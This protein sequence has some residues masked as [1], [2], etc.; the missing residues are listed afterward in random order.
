MQ[1]NNAPGT[2]SNPLLKR[3]ILAAMGLAVSTSVAAPVDA[4]KSSNSAELHAVQYKGMEH[5]AVRVLT[6]A[7]ATSIGEVSSLV[8]PHSLLMRNKVILRVQGMANARALINALPEGLGEVVLEGSLAGRTDAWELTTQ[9]VRSAIKVAEILSAQD[10]V[11]AAF[12]DT[13]RLPNTEAMARAAQKHIAQSRA[14]MQARINNGLVAP[15]IEPVDQTVEPAGTSDPSLANFWHMTNTLPQYLNKD[16]NITQN[17]YDV[18]GYTGN[19]VTVGISRPSNLEH[20]DFA[21]TDIDA[22]YDAMLTM[23]IDTTLFPPDRGM[24]AVAGIIA[25]ERDNGEGGHGIAPEAQFATM[26]TGTDLLLANMLT[27]EINNLDLK[28]IPSPGANE[29]VSPSFAAGYNDGRG[30]DFVGDFFRNALRFGRSGKGSIFVFS[31]GFS[32]GLMPPFPDPYDSDRSASGGLDLSQHGGIDEL[33]VSKTLSIID[34]E[35]G[36]SFDSTL[37]LLGPRYINAQTY[38]YPFANDRLTFLINAVG[39]DGNADMNQAIGPGV[40]ASVYTGTSNPLTSFD[41]TFN[42]GAPAPRGIFATIPGSVLD[43]IPDASTDWTVNFTQFVDLSNVNHSSAAIAGGIIALMLEANPNLSIRDIQHIL[44]E[45]IFDSTRAS[46][47]KFPTF[48]PSR[49]Y[50]SPFA[51]A[52]D[53]TNAND[54]AFNSWSF[55]QVNAALHEMPGGGVAAIR[56]SDQ[57]GFGVI[58]AE[59]AI[60]KA[61]TWTGAPKPVVLDTGLVSEDST[62]GDEEETRV[63]LEI[64]DAEFLE[65]NETT[66]ILQDGASRGDINQINFCV[67]NNIV[68]ESIVVELSVNGNGFNDIFTT[69]TSPYGT[70]SNLTYP[71]TNNSLGTSFDIDLTDDEAELIYSTGTVGNDAVALYRHPI[72]TF[73]H[74][75]ELSGGTWSI[76]FYD[77]GP[78]GENIEGEA[79]TDTDPAV[80]NIHGLGVFG[81]PGSAFRE[82]KEV[83]EFRVRIYGYDAGEAPFLGCNPFNTSCPADLNADGVVNAADFNLF[84]SWYFAGDA[85]ADLNNNGIIDFFDIS[86]YRAIFQP[87]FCT[88]GGGAPPFTGG[89]P[90]PGSNNA[91]DTNPP[92]RPI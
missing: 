85:R 4:S 1:S 56:H 35:E 26:S 37:P 17:I 64:V 15:G 34:D 68:I 23:P 41:N 50:I 90:R 24:T 71:T 58:D 66:T 8:D 74:W 45:S 82:E 91:G 25:A 33:F 63:P 51:Q 10:S 11:N 27:Y 39:E 67:R 16:N 29:F 2:I 22:N 9:D 53:P 62:V 30:A 65:I 54:P 6:P 70:V 7:S 73:K 61:E 28:V 83:I 40:F 75:G 81:L 44:F 69:L 78:D 46:D 92:T 59:L 42:P 19:G 43:E 36:G 87:G 79:S 60:S 80:P 86:A 20:L 77:F 13:G 18:M 72:T 52:G 88:I 12:V 32:L 47:V 21:H 48:D 57:F 49:S 55:W 89:R 31:G 38:M 14:L 76:D 5:K 84:L 3:M